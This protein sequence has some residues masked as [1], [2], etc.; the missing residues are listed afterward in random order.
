M[1]NRIPIDIIHIISRYKNSEKY[2]SAAQ[3]ARLYAHPQ[4]TTQCNTKCTSTHFEGET[5]NLRKGEEATSTGLC[6]LVCSRLQDP[7]LHQRTSSRHILSEAA[8]SIGARFS[9][10]YARSRNDAHTP[11]RNSHYEFCVEATIY[12]TRVRAQASRI[13]K[14]H[15]PTAPSD[16][17]YRL[18]ERWL[19][20]RIAC[21]QAPTRVDIISAND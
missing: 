21:V 1:K 17:P 10:R 14:H 19:D 20:P 3:G 16:E 8:R 7:P 2:K 12:S 9:N 15:P 18:V 5:Y 6:C 11:A 4:D 13:R